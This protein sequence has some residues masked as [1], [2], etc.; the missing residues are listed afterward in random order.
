[1]NN[2][3][4]RTLSAVLV[5]TSAITLA[6]CGQTPLDTL[7]QSTITAQSVNVDSNG[8]GWVGKGDVQTAFNWN[9]AQA[10]RYVQNVTFTFEQSVRY[11]LDCYK[12]VEVGRDR[13][14]KT[15]T[16]TVKRTSNI[17]ATITYEARKTGQWTGYNLKGFSSTDTNAPTDLSCTGDDGN[18]SGWMQ[19]GEPRITSGADGG[20]F[21]TWN[22]I[23]VALPN[24]PIVV[25]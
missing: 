24:T 7:P 10:Q 11:E 3:A 22:S 21:V 14:I 16:R 19:D 6:A 9:N 13:E 2:S 25:Y 23:K 8:V 1:M 5:L 12:E 20:L 17:N 18:R 4:R 15:I